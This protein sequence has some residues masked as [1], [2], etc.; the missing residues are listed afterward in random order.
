MLCRV[1]DFETDL[2][3]AKRA[4]VA[5]LLFRCARLLNERALERV[6]EKRGVRVRASHTSLFPHI[7]LAG[8]RQ[9]ELA[10]KLGV[11]KQA[12]HELVSELES[13]GVVQRSA[14]PDDR[15]ATLVR[16]TPR[17]RKALLDGLSIA[18]DLE[19]EMASA[20]GASNV[21]ALHAALLRLDDWLS[22]SSS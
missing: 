15:R 17:G 2:E 14:D 6:A 22:G 4:S 8:T 16:F 5:Q 12:V 1:S 18:K 21:T 10:R 7:E 13:M 19:A 11:S 9:T 20:I 3:Q